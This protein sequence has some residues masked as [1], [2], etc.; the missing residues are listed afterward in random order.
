M[1]RRDMNCFGGGFC[2]Y[3]KDKIVFRQLNSHKKHR[4]RSNMRRKKTKK[5]IG[6]HSLY[7]PPRQND[8]VFIKSVE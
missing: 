6:Y 8:T 1:F 2:L 4:Y 7:Q 5:K 3:L